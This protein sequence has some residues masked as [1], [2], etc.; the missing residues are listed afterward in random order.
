MHVKTKWNIFYM[1]IYAFSEILCLREV[2][3]RNPGSAREFYRQ[4]QLGSEPLSLPLQE[5]RGGVSF[6]TPSV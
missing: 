5:T 6:L 2:I 3:C 1:Y 4:I